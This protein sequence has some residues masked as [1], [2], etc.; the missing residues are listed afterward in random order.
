LLLISIIAIPLV[1]SDK[2]IKSFLLKVT[3]LFLLLSAAFNTKENYLNAKENYSYSASFLQ[4]VNALLAAEKNSF[5]VAYCKNPDEYISPSEYTTGGLTGAYLQLQ[6]HFYGLVNIGFYSL[7]N[8]SLTAAQHKN[9]FLNQDFYPFVQK[10]KA[11]N[12]FV[13]TEQCQINFLLQHHIQYLALSPKAI[14]PALIQ[15]RIVSSLED[16]KTGEKFLILDI[17]ATFK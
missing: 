8:D 1:K 12:K 16:K 3:V 6:P 5:V 7:L 14:V 10:E 17:S 9:K 4:K 11:E 2:G 13:S 15:K